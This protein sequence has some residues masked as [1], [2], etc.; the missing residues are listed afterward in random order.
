MKSLIG[1]AIMFTSL[2]ICAEWYRNIIKTRRPHAIIR[3]P[4][5]P[6]MVSSSSATHTSVFNLSPGIF[7]F[8]PQFF[9]HSLSPQVSTL[10][11]L[12]SSTLAASVVL[13]GLT[14]AE[15]SH[16]QPKPQDSRRS[17]SYLYRWTMLSSKVPYS[18]LGKHI[19][20]TTA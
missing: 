16:S 17:Q 4:N 12:K 20:S 18:R 6:R 3:S 7:A 15:K 2:S 9:N 8:F 13:H 11:T 5:H 10:N 1:R 14:Q 19:S